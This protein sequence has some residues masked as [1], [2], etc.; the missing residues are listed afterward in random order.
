[1]ASNEGSDASPNWLRN[2]EASPDVE[3]W[4]G[5]RKLRTTPRILHCEAPD[6][7]R[8]WTLMNVVNFARYEHMQA[9]TERPFPIVLL[10][11][12]D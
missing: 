2:L 1:M 6:Y 5:R 10:K 9:K 7:E 3:V 8:L 11:P 12:N 4:I